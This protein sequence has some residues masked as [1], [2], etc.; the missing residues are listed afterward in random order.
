[1]KYDFG[2]YA[3]KNDLK[4]ADGRTIRKDAFKDCD[5]K[6]VPL[7]WQHQ[8]DTPENI[9]GH[10]KLENR[11]DGVYAYGKFNETSTAAN[12]K[13]LVEHGDITAL[14]IYA[15]QLVQS[16][17]K[18]VIH[19]TIREVSLVLAGAN[20]GA[21]I[22]NPIIEHSDGTWEDKVDEAIIF[23][24]VDLT[25]ENLEHADDDSSGKTVGEIFNSLTDEQKQVVYAMVGM[26][27][28]Q[29]DDLDEGDDG[30]GTIQ[31]SL[32]G[33]MTM[34][35]N[36]FEG[37]ATAIKGPSLNHS[38]LKTIFEDAQKCGSLKQSVLAHAQE[39][40]IE[41]IDVL[42]PD[43]K[44]VM[45]TPDLIK[46]RTEWVA[47]VL[48]GTTHSP[49][50]RIKSTAADI[51][52]DEARAK[53]YIKG[54]RKKEE[55]IKVLK[56]VTT[57]TTIYKKQKLDRD[58]IID[59]T[60]FNVVAWLKAEMRLMLDEEIARAILISDGRAADDE[61]KIDEEHL[62]PIWKEEEL[63]V[64][65]LVLDSDL[66]VE[67]TMEKILRG[68]EDYEGAGSPTFY[69]TS[70][71]LIDMKLI[72]DK[73]GHR[74]YTTDA[75]VA[76]A[77]GMGSIVTVPVMKGQRRTLEDGTEVEL[78]GIGINLRDYTVGADRGGE[79]SA[80]DDFDIDYN[81]YKYLM[82]TRISG[83][84]THPKSAIIVEKKVSSTS[85]G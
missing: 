28:E 48:S 40:G 55:I 71:F 1:M 73:I 18:D 39:Y 23:S 6:I 85:M 21:I 14:S 68:M 12:A 62:R 45:N 32:E 36:V 35:N 8:R 17:Q 11:P 34:K 61:D 54:N 37:D 76:N 47:G 65:N 66:S 77:I 7:V 25:N 33:G 13:A 70:S 82:E 52:A 74:Y 46:R 20:P 10:C 79:I 9:L 27:L 83:C 59:I 84:L 42:F 72:K 26:A 2:G 19:G 64:I 63:Y 56:R 16:S 51:T 31:Q 4:C 24:G 81:Q 58:D 44:S 67:D 50:S 29:S 57:P 60:D 38:Q 22:D 5:G 30:D 43:A 15:N 75:E 80:F 69:T 41:N 53:G 49:F 78:V 3:S